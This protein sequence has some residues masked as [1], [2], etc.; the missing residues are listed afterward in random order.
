M[1]EGIENVSAAL[2]ALLRARD[3][4]D[5]KSQYGYPARE[6]SAMSRAQ[7]AYGEALRQF[8]RAAAWMQ[9][10]SYSMARNDRK[11]SAGNRAKA[12]IEAGEAH[13][14]VIAEMDAE[15]KAEAI[16]AALNS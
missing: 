12:R 3:A 4:Y 2:H 14:I 11:A 5:R 15:W 16:G 1:I 6:A 13:E 9:A 10:E 7:A 8:P